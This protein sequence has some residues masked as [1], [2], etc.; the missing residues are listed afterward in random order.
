MSDS[1]ADIDKG[2]LR[3]VI[4]APRYNE[5][6]GG[7]IALHALC[8]RMNELG[9]QAK[10]WSAH[11]FIPKTLSGLGQLIWQRWH[12][13]YGYGPFPVRKARW[14]EIRNSII[15]YPEVAIGNPVDAERIVRWLLYRPTDRQL[16][17]F[18]LSSEMLAYYMP[19]FA[20]TLPDGTMSHHLRIQHFNGEYYDAGHERTEN[21]FVVHKGADRVLDR[22]P[23]DCVSVDKLSHAEKAMIYRRSKRLYSYDLYSMNNI[24]AAVCGCIPVIVPVEGVSV[25]EWMPEEHRRYGLAYG[26]ENIEW[27]I[28]TRDRLLQRLADAE[29]EE[30]RMIHEFVTNCCLHFGITNQ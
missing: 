24:Y 15:V 1:F 25:E 19:S 8:N 23:A 11:K 9:Y 16:S 13:G 7:A 27:A 6:S 17:S 18:D 30:N 28:A 2:Q 10:I 5:N 22:H 20:D 26:E 21:C 14:A 12:L 4:W 3:F 29:A